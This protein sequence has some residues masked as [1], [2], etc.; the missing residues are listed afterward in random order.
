M[1]DDLMAAFDEVMS[2]GG[3]SGSDMVETLPRNAN[4]HTGDNDFIPDGDENDSEIDGLDIE[5]DVDDAVDDVDV[6]DDATDDRFDFDSIKDKT[7]PVTVNGE[8][9]EVPLAELRN[10]Y[11]RQ[12]DYTRKTQQVAADTEM[13]RWAREMQEAF[14][15]D[16]VGSVRYLQEQLGLA[17]QDDDPLEGVDPEMQPI[18][19]ELWRTREELAELRQR[20]EQFDQERTTVQVRAE[21]DL[22]QSKYQDFDPFQVLP[23]AIDNG[24]TMEMAYKI[25][26]ADQMT[27]ESELQRQAREKAENA[28][29]Q[30][31]KARK[32]K[33]Q[34]RKSSGVAGQ[35]DDS[36]KKFDSFEDIFEYE[37]ERTR[38]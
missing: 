22:M 6:V 20:T 13:L 23:I 38:P 8:T 36:W 10:G 14:R 2:G 34:A 33:T 32:A 26:K 25:W 28:A 7:V 17:D 15:V 4:V 21:L 11:M 27:A 5:D 9:F 30:R 16:P 37:F 29:Q 3:D 18:V 31:D 12:A 1:S 24:L 35:N 19:A